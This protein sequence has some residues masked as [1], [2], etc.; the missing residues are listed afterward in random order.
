MEKLN[1]LEVR[2]M[3][4]H[5]TKTTNGGGVSKTAIGVLTASGAATG[6]ALGSIAGPLGLLVG[7]I[8]GGAVAGGPFLIKNWITSGD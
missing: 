7:A 2:E 4:V 1:K 3:T 6:A 8:V 5:E